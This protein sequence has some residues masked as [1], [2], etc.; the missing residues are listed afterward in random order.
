[1]SDETSLQEIEVMVE[2]TVPLPPVEPPAAPDLKSERVQV[3]T[4]EPGGETVQGG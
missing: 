1:M 3:D 4:E 2:P